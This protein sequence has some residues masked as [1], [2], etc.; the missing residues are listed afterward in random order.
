MRKALTLTVTGTIAAGTLIAGA[1]PA[2]AENSLA[3]VR[4]ETNLPI[5]AQVSAARWEYHP[6]GRS[7]GT[8]HTLGGDECRDVWVANE[9]LINSANDRYK[10]LGRVVDAVFAS[11]I[12]VKPVSIGASEYMCW[13]SIGWRD[14]FD[15]RNKYTT[16]VGALTA[17][18][19]DGDTYPMGLET[20]IADE[21]LNSTKQY[22]KYD[23]SQKH[24]YQVRY[25]PASNG[26]NHYNLDWVV[27]AQFPEREFAAELQNL[28]AV[29]LDDCTITGT[30]GND[31]LVGTPGDDVICGL[32]GND[33]IDGGG[34]D[35]VLLGGPGDD[36]IDGGAGDDTLGGGSGDDLMDGGS[37]D[38]TLHGATGEDV[39]LGGDGDDLLDGGSGDDAMVTGNN[40][41][42]I[43]TADHD[44]TNRAV[45]TSGTVLEDSDGDGKSARGLTSTII[46][47]GPLHIE[48]PTGQQLPYCSGEWTTT[49]TGVVYCRLN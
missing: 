47:A 16:F 36:L 20:T 1:A 2:S 9:D 25:E 12:P 43:L 49:Q 34:G 24:W 3:Y 46:G 41:H 45:E 7:I 27:T 31:E 38:D 4:N 17:I 28:R 21:T 30:P 13:K 5:T 33:T 15:F 29:D 22:A 40:G 35:D 23:T 14:T 11:D 6:S 10:D 19:A 42:G 8:T 44:G 26:D 37:G 32:D 18:G 39:L 48:R